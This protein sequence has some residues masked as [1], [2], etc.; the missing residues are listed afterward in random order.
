VSLKER[1]AQLE[2]ERKKQWEEE[3]KIRKTEVEV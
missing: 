3:E 2:F 1:I